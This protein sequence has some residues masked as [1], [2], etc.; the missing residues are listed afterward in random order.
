MRKV[1]AIVGSVALAGCIAVALAAADGQQMGWV[2]LV[3]QSAAPG[4]SGKARFYYN[5]TDNTFRGVKVDNSEVSFGA[6][7]GGTLATTYTNG[8][9]QTD[10]TMTLDSTRL[11]VRIKDAASPISG[12]LFTVH[13][14]ADNLN[15]FAVAKTGAVIASAV[16]TSGSPGQMLIVTPGAH[17]GM[18][19][20]TEQQAIVL[21]PV[22]QQWA[23]GAIT[24]QRYVTLGQQTLAFVGASTVTN[25]ATVAI[26]GAPIAGTNATITNAYALWVQAG[27]TQLDGNLGVAAN[28]TLTGASSATNTTA[29][30]LSATVADGATSIAYKLDAPTSQATSGGRLFSLQNVGA[31]KFGVSTVNRSGTTNRPT[32]YGDGSNAT[33]QLS[34]VGGTRLTYAGQYLG[35]ND[36]ITG[37][38]FSTLGVDR[39]YI[40]ATNFYP[41]T[42]A[43]AITLGK[44]ANRFAGVWSMAYEG[45]QEAPTF[46]ATM[47]FDCTT[48][49]ETKRVVLT[50]NLGSW[51]MTN[52]NAGQVC[53]LM[54]VQDGTGS[55]TIGTPPSNVSFAGG[56]P[57]LTTTI[58]KTDTFM[59]RWN[60]TSSKW[61]EIGRGLN[62]T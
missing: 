5:A 43:T 34:D 36:S 16:S 59:L 33:L 11:G 22:T 54:L 56:T 6:G 27:K 19:A 42:D 32:I 8:A 2:E 3:T 49:G 18:T 38:N 28:W 55:R 15:Y 41:V 29:I 24:T 31:E 9:S 20:G 17:T 46:G 61:M 51:T 1:L 30:A 10:S 39:I 14:N 7:G 60:T 62:E 47:N 45:A 52:G 44:S 4:R 26:V 23:T 48:N 21:Y 40:D 12:N 57:T 13:N 37:F 35:I 53:T 50:A 25:A 58:N